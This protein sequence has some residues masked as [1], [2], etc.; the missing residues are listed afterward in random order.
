MPTSYTAPVADGT[1]TDL[2]R[3]AML[4]ARAF[5]ATISM[6][7]D[8]MSAPIPMVIEPDGYYRRRHQQAVAEVLRLQRLS[9]MEAQR[10]M[11][12]EHSAAMARWR[13]STWNDARQVVRY[14]TMI[15]HVDAWQPPSLEHENFK[16]FM[17]QQLR[18]SLKFDCG[19]R[20]RPM[21]RLQ[22]WPEWLRGAI[23]EAMDN[24]NWQRKRREE[25]VQRAVNATS[26][27][28]LLRVSLQ[29]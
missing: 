19:G 11:Q 1:I 20:F 25:D 15:E 3:F 6:R 12:Q 16:A 7:D 9:P 26:W 28:A 13:D 10:E 18:D 2:R 24:I 8:P 27:L 4:C 14:Q 23:A 5:G 21:P 29:E 22:R 17:L